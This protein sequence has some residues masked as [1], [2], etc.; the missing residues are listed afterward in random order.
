[1]MFN[2]LEMATVSQY[3][4]SKEGQAS[5][6][7]EIAA[8][9]RTLRAGKWR[10]FLGKLTGRESRLADLAQ[11]H[12]VARQAPRSSGVVNV[13][14]ARIVGSEGRTHDFDGAFRPLSDCT[15]DRWVSI[16]AAYRNHIPLPPVVLIQVADEYYV[17]D[18]HHRVSV[19]R[20]VGQVEI[21]GRV[22]YKLVI[23]A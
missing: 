3:G 8:F 2:S 4:L 12:A 16:A 1:M 19:A 23:P 20:A 7:K 17:R 5:R 21:E 18:G 14:L 6:F 11:V 22:A 13:P 15:R 9:E 10:A